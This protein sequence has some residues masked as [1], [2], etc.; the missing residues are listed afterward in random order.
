[1]LQDLVKLIVDS[2]VAPR[3][4]VRRVIDRAQNWEDIAI[5]FGLSFTLSAMVM[6][7]RLDDPGDGGL[8]LILV[9]LLVSAIGLLLL[10]FIA[11]GVGKLFG[12]KGELK[13]LTAAMAW[14]SLVTVVFAPFLSP[15]ALL[16]TEEARSGFFLQVALL[17]VVIW[18]MVNFIAE[19]HRFQSAWKVAG[20]MAALIF[21]PAILMSFFFA[22]SM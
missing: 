20:V 9:N 1:M 19:A 8:A 3:S 18:L 12:G 16:A 11:T 13:E 7:L 22:G 15:A 2:Y 6:T 17:L 5:V 14:H 10:S 4:A 21:L